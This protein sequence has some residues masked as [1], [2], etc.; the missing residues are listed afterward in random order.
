MHTAI[1]FPQKA[2][3]TYELAGS[4]SASL[5]LGQFVFNVGARTLIEQC[6]KGVLYRILSVTFSANCSE[7]DFRQAFVPVGA[8]VEPMA[9]L[10]VGGITVSPK[11]WPVRNFYGSR[12]T[13]NYFQPTADNQQLEIAFAGTFDGASLPG[14]PTLTLSYSFTVQELAA[15]SWLAAYDQGKF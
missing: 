8:V 4:V 10:T 11:G 2:S 6:R 13:L 7:T 14:L 1:P 5:V 3:R 12:D 9:L 15:A